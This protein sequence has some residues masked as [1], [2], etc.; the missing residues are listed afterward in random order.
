M[1]LSN[2]FF[3]PHPTP[4]PNKNTYA[5]T[6]YSEHRDLYSNMGMRMQHTICLNMMRLESFR[7]EVDKSWQSPRECQKLKKKSPINDFKTKMI[8]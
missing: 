6:H 2:I 8:S 3:N 4:H 7:P 1:I 5:V